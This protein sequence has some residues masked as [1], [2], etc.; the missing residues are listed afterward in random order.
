MH[1]IICRMRAVIQRVDRASVRVN[2]EVTGAVGKGL[3]VFLGV[4]KGDAESDANYL[5]GKIS[6]LRLF[7]DESGKMNLSVADTGG[8]LLIVSQFTLYADTRKGRRPSFDL[9]APPEAA[10]YLYDYFVG[11]AK[12]TGLP[13]ETGVFQASMEVE[14][15]N[16]GPVTLILDS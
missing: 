10:R 8:A 7:S 14:I 13:V 15:V 16:Q 12:A 9:A 1:C 6:T 5:I 2:G 11:A 4:A 3:L